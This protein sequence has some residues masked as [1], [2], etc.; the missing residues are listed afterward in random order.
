V[1]VN[2]LCRLTKEGACY[3]SGCVADA[4]LGRTIRECTKGSSKEL[5]VERLVASTPV[6]RTMVSPISVA[7]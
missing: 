4:S 5:N 7:P 1:F 3:Q 2:V 6:G